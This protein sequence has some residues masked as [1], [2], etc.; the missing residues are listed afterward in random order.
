MN[1]SFLYYAKLA[2]GIN[3]NCQVS[4]FLCLIVKSLIT[5]NS[6]MQNLV[7]LVTGIWRQ[8]VKTDSS[9]VSL[10]KRCEG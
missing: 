7:N 3:G 4:H 8:L 6:L 2:K 9:N 10:K 1:D 5:A